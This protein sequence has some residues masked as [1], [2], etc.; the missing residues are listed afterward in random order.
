MQWKA[1][2]YIPGCIIPQLNWF[3]KKDVLRILIEGK[4]IAVSEDYNDATTQKNTSNKYQNIT[5]VIGAV[6]GESD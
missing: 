3:Q 6:M 4:L 2:Q 5:Q 1:L